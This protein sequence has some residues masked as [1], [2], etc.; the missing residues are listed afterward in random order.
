MNEIN[1]F[2]VVALPIFFGLLGFVEPCSIGSTL[3]VLKQ[4]EGLPTRAKIVR[5]VMFAATR[6]V[7]IDLL[8]MLAAV[9]GAASLIFALLGSAAAASTTGFVSLGLFGFALSLPLVVVVF[10]APARAA[11]DALHALSRRAPLWTG[12]VLVSLGA[13]SVWFALFVFLKA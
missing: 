2:H 6:A 11:L 13:W 1:L 7:F 3:L 5:T 9:L 8:G 4:I 10:F 12:V